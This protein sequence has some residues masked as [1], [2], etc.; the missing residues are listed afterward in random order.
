MIKMENRLL[1]YSARETRRK[2]I[3]DHTDLLSDIYM[4][5]IVNL[6]PTHK[7]VKVKV[8]EINRKRGE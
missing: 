4:K 6:P 2:A 7:C 3:D 1:L 5:H 8:K